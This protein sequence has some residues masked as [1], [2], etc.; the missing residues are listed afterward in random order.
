MISTGMAG[1]DDLLGGGIPRGSKVLYSMEPGVNG[2]LFMISTIYEA[3]AKDLSCLVILPHTTVDAFLHDAAK[4]RG[5]PL[6]ITGKKCAF[7]DMID[8]ERIQRCAPTPAAAE[9]EWRARITKLCQENQTE[10]IFAYFDVIYEDFG[11]DKGFDLLESCKTDRRP[12]IILEHLNFEGNFLIEQFIKKLSFDLVISIKASFDLF[13]HFN[14]FILMHASW[15]PLQKRAVPFIISNGRIVPYIPK[16]V[17]IGPSESGKSTFVASISE[18]GQSVDRTGLSGDTTTVA[19]DFGWLHWK[20]FDITLYG[21]PGQPRFDLLLP[22]L[23]K[24]AMGA[25]ILIDAT[26]PDSLPRAKLLI[27]MVVE[28]RIPMVVA[29]NKNDL[30]DGMDEAK[31]RAALALKKEV[32]VFFIS[33]KRKEDVR[34]VLES[35]V[36]FITQFSY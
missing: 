1:I 16:I 25:V 31:I 9:K 17:V 18:H 2:Q 22:M 32:P 5:S 20:D 26:K 13:P 10:V 14:F 3:L 24:N 7:F 11:L 12:T 15:A 30:P 36:D 6:D 27:S 23:L 28:R 4:M 21:T 34:F 33:A 8:R 19:M 35:L 29:A